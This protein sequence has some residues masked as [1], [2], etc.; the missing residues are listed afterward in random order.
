[1]P[2]LIFILLDAFRWDYLQPDTA[3]T[4]WQLKEQG[5]YAQKLRPSFGFCELTESATGARPDISEKFTQLTF[6][7]TRHSSSKKNYLNLL[8]WAAEKVKNYG[9]RGSTRMTRWL[10]KDLIRPMLKD[11]QMSTLS[12]NIPLPLLP[13][14][15]AVEARRYTDRGAFGIESCFD[16]LTNAGYKI[17]DDTYV[18]NNKVSGPDQDRVAQLTS[19]VTSDHDLYMI[20]L[21]GCD[22][23][24][25]NFGPDSQELKNGVTQQDTWIAQ[26]IKTFPK[27]S[28]FLVVGD[29]GMLN[30]TNTIDIAAIIKRE[31]PQLKHTRDFTLFLDSTLARVWWHNNQTGQALQKLFSHPPFTPKGMVIDE[32]EAKHLCIP[33][34][35][36][37]YGQI[38]WR[39]NPGVMIFPDYFN[40][41]IPVGMHGYPTHI[42]EQKGM[43]ILW[44]KD[45]PQGHI[46]EVELIDICPT[47]CDLFQLPSPKQNQ[48]RSLLDQIG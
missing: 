5:L 41:K 42:D 34:P 19:K 33:P 23:Y 46:D 22:E 16:V 1:M 43:A 11:P 21:G 48:G 29:H 20:Y 36:D 7:E 18:I 27:D 30:V 9:G 3:P 8:N 47:I 40:A 15:T 24:G 39:A 12:Y 25:H 44:G 4:L 10:T 37:R 45:I 35:G 32:T 17:F 14:L 13:L 38:I 2:P 31:L 26:L 28:R 6:I